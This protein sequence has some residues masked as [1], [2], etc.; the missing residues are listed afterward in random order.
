MGSVQ[1]RRWAEQGRRTGHC[2]PPWSSDESI[3][4]VALS[5]F[6][7][8]WRAVTLIQTAAAGGT[9]GVLR[10]ASYLST[11]LSAVLTRLQLT[12]ERDLLQLRNDF[13]CWLVH[14]LFVF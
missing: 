13:L 11:V 2:Q 1:I 5:A 14:T 7:Q 8:L 10:I 12:R 4:L 9:L 6:K 3:G